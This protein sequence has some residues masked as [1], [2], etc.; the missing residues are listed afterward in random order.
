MYQNL[1]KH[2]LPQTKWDQ[3]VQGQ[4]KLEIVAGCNSELRMMTIL[5]RG[6]LSVVE[7]DASQVLQKSKGLQQKDEIAFG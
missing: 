4:M 1:R 6:L 3:V 2:F 7:V 5:I